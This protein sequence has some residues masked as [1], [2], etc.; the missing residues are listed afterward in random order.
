MSC[1][2]AYKRLATGAMFAAVVLALPVVEASDST[3]ANEVAEATAQQ[4]LQHYMGICGEGVPE[5]ASDMLDM[6]AQGA[7]RA[8]VKREALQVHD[9]ALKRRRRE[10]NDLTPKLIRRGLTRQGATA[11]VGAMW[12][13]LTAVYGTLPDMADAV[14][15][16]D[17]GRR[18]KERR[19]RRYAMDVC[20]D[21]IGLVTENLARAMHTAST[22]ASSGTQGGGNCVPP[23]H[24]ADIAVWSNFEQ[25]LRIRRFKRLAAKRGERVPRI[26][27]LAQE[28][29]LDYPIPAIR[30]SWSD[31][32]F[33][34]TDEDEVLKEAKGKLRMVADAMDR[35][36]GDI[37]LFVIGHTDDTGSRSY[38][39]SLSQRRALNVL[40]ELTALGVWNAQ[41]TASG[42]G[43]LQPVADNNTDKGRAANRRVE[44][45]ISPYQEANYA[46]VSAR[47]I[48]PAFFQPLPLPEKEKAK[49]PQGE[50]SSSPRAV[51]EVPI[52][53]RTLGNEQKLRFLSI[54]NKA[55]LK[56]LKLGDGPVS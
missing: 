51:P 54:P 41:M 40:H 44:F 15:D 48:N 42:M 47:T 53:V 19:F 35:D 20:M 30:I 28:G 14:F 49:L 5:I 18:W 1:T 9:D 3:R 39:Q 6:R 13:M 24:G 29:L 17:R 55:P 11:M 33:F 7:R 21:R 10:L 38:N 50:E 16:G 23:K 56:P 26:E 32:V 34:G 37:H 8:Q 45:M 22:D 2:F 52:P 36:V 27:S 46:L 4:A 31:G 12:K 43:E 25:C